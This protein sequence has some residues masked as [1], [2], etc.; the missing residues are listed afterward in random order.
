MKLKALFILFVL[1]GT[2]LVSC[3]D[4]P[5]NEVI[6]DN[7]LAG[8]PNKGPIQ[9]D[10]PA[11]GQ[12]SYYVYYKVTSKDETISYSYPGD[13]LIVFIS[14]FKS[15]GWVIKEFLTD[16]SIS[17]KNKSTSG[18]G[19]WKGYAD[20]VF[21]STLNVDDDSVYLSRPTTRAYNS[22]AF[23]GKTGLFRLHRLRI[24]NP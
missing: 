21:V 22:F 15:N 4:D 8:L 6:P 17:K 5:V 12:R 11:I 10:N 9:L 14:G 16:G 19:S 18:P 20:S 13:T 7:P 2:A 23:S 1:I 3:T 24:P